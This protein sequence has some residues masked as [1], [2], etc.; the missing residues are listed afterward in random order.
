LAQAETSSGLIAGVVRDAVTRAPLGGVRATVLNLLGAVV[1]AYD[2]GPD[3]TYAVSAAPGSYVVDFSKEGYLDLRYFGVTVRDGET[4]YLEPVLQVDQSHAGIG[5]ISGRALNAL[6]GG[7]VPGLTLQIRAGM[8]ALEGAVV[9]SS[10]TGDGGAFAFIGL[11]AGAYTA[12]V[13]GAGY[14]TAHFTLVCIGGQAT[15][16]QNVTI[17]PVLPLGETR[18]VLTWGEAPRD[19]DSHTTGP[20][21]D[22]SRFHMYYPYAEANSGSPWPGLVTLDLDDTTS[23]GPETT[24]LYEQLPGVYRFSVHDYTSRGS[25]DSTA[26]SLSSAQVRVYRSE[27]LVAVFNVPSE[28]GGTLWSVFEL[29]GN[30][31]TPVNTLSYQSD[32]AG[33]QALR[34]AGDSDWSPTDLPAK[35]LQP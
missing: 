3:G 6:S 11:E 27:G 15:S 1:A 35:E 23:Y 32:P 25:S 22:G 19:L 20:L 24:T 2:T 28:V 4:T 30:R 5:N 10:I 17:T 12:E 26:L 33:V 31:I 9:A 16:D 8:G 34:A 18:I 29:D 7:G 14:L 13:S 21:P